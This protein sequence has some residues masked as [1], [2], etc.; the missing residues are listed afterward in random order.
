MPTLKKILKGEVATSR[1]GLE[2]AVLAKAEKIAKRNGISRDEAERQVWAEDGVTEAYEQLPV[3]RPQ[4]RE[5]PIV[6]A[7][8][9]EGVLDERARKRMKRTGCTYA[10]ACSDEVMAD[11][12]LYQR[13]E[14]EI[15]AGMT[16][17][18]PQPPEY[19][20]LPSLTGDQSMSKRGIRKDDPSGAYDECPECSEDVDE[21]DRYC[22]A[23]GASLTTKPAA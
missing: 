1:R 23:C 16:Y 11:P 8:A 3:G 17:D 6:K 4:A 7:T 21:D 20:E 10:K 18:V 5:R 19:L 12:S 14:K 2:E 22:S 9:A 13:Y 15:A